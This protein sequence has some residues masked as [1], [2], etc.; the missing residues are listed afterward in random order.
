MGRS[1]RSLVLGI[2]VGLIILVANMYRLGPIETALTADL[3]AVVLAYVAQYFE[4]LDWSKESKNPR[5]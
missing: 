4:G 3:V 2:V 5:S 1:R